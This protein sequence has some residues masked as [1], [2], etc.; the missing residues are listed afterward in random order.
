[1]LLLIPYSHLAIKSISLVK[2]NLEGFKDD[3]RYLR[4]AFSDLHLTI[5][6]MV[7]QNDTVWVRMVAR[8][9]NGGPFMGPPTG[10]AIAITVMD[11]CRF[12]DGRL[13]E[14]W[15]SP[16]RFALLVQLGLLPKS[17]NSK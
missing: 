6:D 3:I 7:A 14:H 17:A 13:I 10:K 8:G 9:T 11:V 2:K 12:Q 15:G 1:M 16:D 4:T 5:E